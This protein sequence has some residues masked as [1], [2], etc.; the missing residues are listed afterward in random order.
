M[1]IFSQFFHKKCLVG[2]QLFRSIYFLEAVIF[3]EADKTRRKII[4]LNYFKLGFPAVV[5]LL[6]LKYISVN[7]ITRVVFILFI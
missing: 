2:R 6:I 3:L 5:L 4:S 1:W 7:F